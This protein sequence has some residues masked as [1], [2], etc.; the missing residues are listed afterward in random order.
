M[1]SSFNNHTSRSN[2][3]LQAYREGHHVGGGAA[4][5]QN[6]TCQ[7]DKWGAGVSPAADRADSVSGLND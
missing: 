5:K 6:F 1:T 7:R 2:L 3:S 4:Q